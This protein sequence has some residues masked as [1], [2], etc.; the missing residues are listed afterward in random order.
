MNKV[1]EIKRNGKWSKVQ[2]ESIVTLNSW[3]EKNNVSNWRM[4][5][6]MSR[7]EINEAKKLPIVS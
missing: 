6:M 1:F 4:V 7:S 3:A 2:S 5:G